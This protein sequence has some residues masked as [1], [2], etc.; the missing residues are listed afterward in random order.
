MGPS[1]ILYELVDA[2]R[3]QEPAT[4]VIFVVDTGEER[5]AATGS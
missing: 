4:S 3:G 1:V 2:A 5:E